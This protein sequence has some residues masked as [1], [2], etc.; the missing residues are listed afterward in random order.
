[1]DRELTPAGIWHLFWAVLIYQ[2]CLTVIEGQGVLDESAYC[3][4]GGTMA[5]RN[6]LYPFYLFHVIAFLLTFIVFFFSCCLKYHHV[7]F[8]SCIVNFALGL[9]SL[10]LYF[11][12]FANF[13]KEGKF[14]CN[15]DNAPHAYGLVITHVVF[16]WFL[17]VSVGLGVLAAIASFFLKK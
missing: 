16:G 12:L 14:E 10:W 11:D 5:F 13:Y 7:Y 6:W 15:A 9:W 1:M 17:F 8:M 4:L 2:L 3:S